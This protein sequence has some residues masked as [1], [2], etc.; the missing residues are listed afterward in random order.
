MSGIYLIAVLIVTGGAI[1]FIGDR[2]GTKIGKKRLS[3]FGLRPR[4]TSNV[5]T[6]I[7]GFIITA[8]TIGIMSMTSQNVRTALFGLEELNENLALKQSELE[9]LSAELITAKQEYQQANE[10]L[11][12]SKEEVDN[13]QKE[14][15]TLRDEST[16]LKAENIEIEMANAKLFS[17]NEQLTEQNGSLTASNEELARNNSALSNSNEKLKSDNKDL[18][19]RNNRLREGLVAIREGDIVFRAGEI[20][21][22]GVI[23]GGREAEEIVKDIDD[24]AEVATANIARRIGNSGEEAVWI[25]QPELKETVEKISQSPGDMVLRIISA[26]NLMKGE[27]VRTSLE[28]FRNDKIYDKGEF[29]FTRAYELTDKFNAEGLVRDFLG[30][31]NR[32]AVSKGVLADPITGAVGVMEGSQLYQV[33][34]AVAHGKGTII[35]SAYARDVTTSIGPLRLNIEISEAKGNL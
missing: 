6:I 22:S 27:P 33:V 3:I 12:K 15:L 34:D 10:A 35:L 23:K 8:L 24:L 31:V 2:L 30:E 28:L 7:T 1:A 13:L 5:I 17:E 20:L 32:T 26:G 18:E 21:A 19:T 25:Y 14:Q 4:H 9:T 29:I 11:D 16:K